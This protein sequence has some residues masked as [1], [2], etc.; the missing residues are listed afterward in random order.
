MN[1]AVVC[2]HLETDPT[3]GVKKNRRTPLSRFLSR[4][5]IDRLHRAAVVAARDA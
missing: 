5:E 2:G 1:H 3:R 4:E